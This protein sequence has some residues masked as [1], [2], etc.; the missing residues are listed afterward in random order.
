MRLYTEIDVEKS[1][2]L[3]TFAHTITLHDIREMMFTSSK[4]RVLALPTL[5]DARN[6]SI[7]LSPEDVG[8]ILQSS[9]ELATQSM[10]AKCAVLVSD[11]AVLRRVAQVCAVLSQISPLRA[12]LDRI[13]AERWLG[14]SD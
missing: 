6:V 11:E 3:V 5:L 9:K 4:A 14:W 8:E 13:E 10:I 7:G 12:F 2:V 1:R